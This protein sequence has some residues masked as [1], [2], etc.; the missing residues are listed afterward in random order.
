MKFL[1]YINIFFLFSSCSNNPVN[2]ANE[3]KNLKVQNIFVTDITVSSALI[4]WTCSSEVE[5]V[6]LYGQEFTEQRIFI[7]F[8]SKLHRYKLENLQNNTNYKYLALC[9]KDINSILSYNFFL[10]FKTIKKDDPPPPP[11]DLTAVF[12]RGIWL[13]GGLNSNNDRPSSGCL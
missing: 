13:V 11:V 8:K 6:L 5:A 2:K 12:N 1:I 3:Y 4:T 7:P 9:S 10:S